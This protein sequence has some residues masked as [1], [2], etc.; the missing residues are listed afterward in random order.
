MVFLIFGTNTLLCE[1][2]DFWLFAVKANG[3]FIVS[4]LGREETARLK[5]WYPGKWHHLQRHVACSGC[6]VAN[7]FCWTCFCIL[8]LW[9][10]CT[11][12]FPIA[13]LWHALHIDPSLHFSMT[14]LLDLQLHL[15]IVDLFMK[16]IFKF[17]PQPLCC[18]RLVLVLFKFLKLRT[19]KR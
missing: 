2:A 18:K 7:C 16:Y 4:L 15:V 17:H 19:W 6:H 9:N 14:V 10:W 12:I 1:G 13:V 11:F 3:V 8:M 5:Q